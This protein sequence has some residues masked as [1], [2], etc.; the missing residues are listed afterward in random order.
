MSGEYNVSAADLDRFMEAIL[1]LVQ[2]TGLIIA[3]A[4][5]TQGNV[6]IDE[7]EENIGEGN[8]SAILTETDLKVIISQVTKLHCCKMFFLRFV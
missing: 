6:E 4:I 1:A 3:N 8:A 2:E 7:K 5:G